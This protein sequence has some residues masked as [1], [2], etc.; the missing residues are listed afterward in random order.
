MPLKC[1]IP[2]KHDDEGRAQHQRRTPNPPRDEIALP[3]NGGSQH[4]ASQNPPLTMSP[5]NLPEVCPSIPR[6]RKQNILLQSNPNPCLLILPLLFSRSPLPP[7]TLLIFVFQTSSSEEIMLLR[8]P[9]RKMY[10]L[11][12]Q[13]GNRFALRPQMRQVSCS[14][15]LTLSL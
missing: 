6:L 5:S 4:P 14:T 3:S 2:Y 9:T 10:I 15:T 13:N 7:K 1:A 8:S 12:L 11:L